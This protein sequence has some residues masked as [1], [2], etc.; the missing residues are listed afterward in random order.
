ME[1]KIH[2]LCYENGFVDGLL[3]AREFVHD[4]E[5][6][7]LLEEVIRQ[8]LETRAA[9]LLDVHSDSSLLRDESLNFTKMNCD[10]L[11]PIR[12]GIGRVESP[13]APSVRDLSPDAKKPHP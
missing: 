8:S 7:L 9:I 4:E 12:E 13:A 10:S 5:T 6:R 2:T 3:V 11:T 1:E